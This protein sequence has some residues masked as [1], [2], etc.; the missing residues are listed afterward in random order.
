MDIPKILSSA[1]KV[2]ATE[3]KVE[4]GE[5]TLLVIR[6]EVRTLFASTVK[7]DDFEDGIIRRL[8]VFKRDELR[9]TGRCN[10]EFQESGIGRIQ[11]EIESTKAR[12]LLPTTLDTRSDDQSSSKRTGE[13]KRSLLSKLFGRE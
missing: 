4:I 6:G 5:P 3:A 1:A 11:A 7:A 13:P 10:W 2:K 9:N 8:D 12:F